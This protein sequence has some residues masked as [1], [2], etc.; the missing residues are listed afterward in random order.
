MMWETTMNPETRRLIQVTEYN[1]EYTKIAFD[2]LLGDDLQSRK[3]YIENFGHLYLEQ[4]DE[5]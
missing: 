5:M 3:E 2:T 1:P 4:V